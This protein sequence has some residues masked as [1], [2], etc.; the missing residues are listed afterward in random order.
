MKIGDVEPVFLIENFLAIRRRQHC[1]I[2]DQMQ[3]ADV[4]ILLESQQVAADLFRRAD[5]HAAPKKVA[6]SRRGRI[7]RPALG[8]RGAR[9]EFGHSLNR[10]S[11]CGH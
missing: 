11:Q 5:Q 4:W 7:T 10:L 6:M 1:K 8:Q 2:V 3:N 9:L